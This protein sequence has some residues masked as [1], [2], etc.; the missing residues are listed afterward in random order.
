MIQIRNGRFAS[1]EEDSKSER[2]NVSGIGCSNDSLTG[3]HVGMDDLK[4]GFGPRTLYHEDY[5]AKSD[6]L[7]WQVHE[8]RE[9]CD[10]WCNGFLDDGFV[11]S[12]GIAGAEEQRV[13]LNLVDK[14]R[15]LAINQYGC[16]TRIMSCVFGSRLW[17][18]ENR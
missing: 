13:D 6:T 3:A 14:K 1:R 2:A 17:Q 9:M 5:K 16:V 12:T 8:D 18:S 10:V 7:R 11:E 4:E 15:L